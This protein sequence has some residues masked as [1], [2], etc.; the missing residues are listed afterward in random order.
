M[1]VESS[2]ASIFCRFPTAIA[3]GGLV[4]VYPFA[5][6]FGFADVLDI[7]FNACQAVYDHI[8]V[9]VSRGREFEFEGLAIGGR[10]DLICFREK[11]A[12]LAGWTFAV[13]TFLGRGTGAG[14][15]E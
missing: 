6:V 4:V 2:A 7:A 8:C 3:D 10:G 15:G 11:R 5:K 14:E 1:G 12:H 13:Q 9:A